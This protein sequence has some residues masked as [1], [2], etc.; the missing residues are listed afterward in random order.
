MP[1]GALTI[2]AVPMV[3]MSHENRLVTVATGGTLTVLRGVDV[4]Y[5]L[6]NAPE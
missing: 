5:L 2:G 4:T 6:S 1:L 3:H